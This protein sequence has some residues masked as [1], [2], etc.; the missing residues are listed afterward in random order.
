VAIVW[1]TTYGTTNLAQDEGVLTQYRKGEEHEEF[2]PETWWWWWW[3][4]ETLR[5]CARYVT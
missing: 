4:C 3:W 1:N 2:C 5:F